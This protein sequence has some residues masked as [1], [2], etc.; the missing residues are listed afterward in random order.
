[1]Q[2]AEKGKSVFTIQFLMKS[3]LEASEKPFGILPYRLGGELLVAFSASWIAWIVVSMSSSRWAAE[4]NS[5]S[6]WLHGI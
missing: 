4:T 6:N 3:W 2:N 5:A 1:M